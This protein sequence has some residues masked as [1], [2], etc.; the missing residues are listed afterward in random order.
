VSWQHIKTYKRAL[1]Y[2]STDR[3]CSLFWKLCYKI[4]DRTTQGGLILRTVVYIDRQS[5]KSPYQKLLAAKVVIV[6]CDAEKE[7]WMTHFAVYLGKYFAASR[8]KLWR[9]N[10][11]EKDRDVRPLS[12]I[13]QSKRWNERIKSPTFEWSCGMWMIHRLT[14]CFPRYPEKNFGR[15]TPTIPL[16]S[17]VRMNTIA[18]EAS[19]LPL[20]QHQF[21]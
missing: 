10:S 20:R 14:Q 13:H 4:Q 21:P 2:S 5:T 15:R 12:K 19:A 6:D 9:R 11:L 3:S 1:N 7:M 18:G 17:A 16:E 8:R